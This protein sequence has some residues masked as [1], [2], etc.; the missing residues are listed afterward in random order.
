MK[1]TTHPTLTRAFQRAHTL[2]STATTARGVRDYLREHRGKPAAGAYTLPGL[3]RLNERAALIERC[4]LERLAGAEIEAQHYLASALQQ[5]QR[6]E[7][8]REKYRQASVL[9]CSPCWLHDSCPSDEHTG[10]TVPESWMIGFTVPPIVVPPAIPKYTPLPPPRVGGPLSRRTFSQETR[11]ARRAAND[12]A[13]RRGFLARLRAREKK[14]C[15]YPLTIPGV[16]QRAESSAAR[17]AELATV[18]RLRSEITGKLGEPMALPPITGAVKITV[19]ERTARKCGASIDM[20]GKDATLAPTFRSSYGIHEA[21]SWAWKDSGKPAKDYCAGKHGTEYTRATHDNFV[22]SFAIPRGNRAEYVCHNT[23]ATIVL[24]EGYL[25]DVDANGLRALDAS[26]RHVD[27]HPEAGELLRKNAAALIV[28]AL[29]ENRE[30]RNLMRAHQAAEAAQ[31]EGVYVCLADSVRAGN[32]RAGSE[33]FAARHNLS[34]SRH[35]SAPE[36]L[37]MA[38]GEAGRVR[39]AITA[40]RLRHEREMAHGFTVLSEHQLSA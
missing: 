28:E 29:E 1:N 18:A 23:L 32:C 30:R 3:T 26:S 27:Y 22:R 4:R 13:F 39:M 6:A 37:A 8:E 7:W 36:L 14:A 12:P 40:A 17:K 2:G 19:D 20:R 15:A 9:G 24:P 21:S 35:Y 33:S 34:L 16:T 10:E 5:E 11:D 31:L 25:W 38:N